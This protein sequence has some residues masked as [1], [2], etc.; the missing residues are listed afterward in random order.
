MTQHIETARQAGLAALEHILKSLSRNLEISTKSNPRDIVTQ[1]DIE[2]ETLIRN[3]IAKAH[4]DHSFLG[5]EH[6]R[7]GSSDHCWIIDPIDGTNNFAK[8][9]PHYCVSIA[10][11]H[12]KELILGLIQ[13]PS[14]GDSYQT[15]RQKGAYKNQKALKVN[16]CSSLSNAYVTMSFASK[17]EDIKEAIPVWNSLLEKSHVTRRMGSTALELAYLAEGKTD[18]FL[19]AGQSLWD[20][21]AG[22]LLVQ[23]A[24]GVVELH[25]NGAVCLAAATKTLMS[26]LKAI[27]KPLL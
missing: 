25:N 9:I 4:P 24:G 17:P 19:G 12:Q 27:A 1:V 22:I 6:G 8:N 16:H 3:I 23:E 14:N 2:T 15:E 11:E 10:L 7:T 5:E 20:Y 18:A 13:N 26:E 21:A